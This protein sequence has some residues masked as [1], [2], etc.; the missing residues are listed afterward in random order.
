MK[1]SYPKVENANDLAWTYMNTKKNKKINKKRHW[2]CRNYYMLCFEC[3][4]RRVGVNG[5][6]GAMSCCLWWF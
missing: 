5:V 3:L 4:F 1:L 2:T 6:L